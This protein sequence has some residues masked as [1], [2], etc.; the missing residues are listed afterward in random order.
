[1]TYDSNQKQNRVLFTIVIYYMII[2]NI[3][4]QTI[5]NGL[6]VNILLI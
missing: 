6:L 5:I 4:S 2:I 1:M 3:T